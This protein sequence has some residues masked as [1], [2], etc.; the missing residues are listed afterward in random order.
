ML[1]VKVRHYNQHYLL[2]RH[3]NYPNGIDDALLW[4]VETRLCSVLRFTFIAKNKMKCKQN[5]KKNKIYR[6]SEASKWSHKVIALTIDMNQ[7]SW[8]VF[9]HRSFRSKFQSKSY[10]INWKTVPN[11]FSVTFL[12]LFWFRFSVASLSRDYHRRQM[13]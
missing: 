2:E 8:F 13:K 6:I 12:L 10:F 1:K 5:E 7:M 3:N 9:S 4:C 11:E